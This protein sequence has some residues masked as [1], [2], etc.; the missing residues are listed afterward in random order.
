MYVFVTLFLWMIAYL[1]HFQVVKSDEIV[2]SPYNPRQNILSAYVIRGN[3][4][5]TN[6]N[7]LAK[8][9]VDSDGVEIRT[10]PMGELY[11]HVVGYDIMGK[12]GVELSN[13]FNLLTSNAFFVEKIANELKEQKNQGDSIVTSLDTNLQK[14][15]YN[16]LGSYDGSVVVMEVSTGKILASVSKPSFD[17]SFQSKSW[18]DIAASGE[19]VLVNRATQG[20]YIPGSIFKITTLIEY[21][22]ENP[23]YHNYTYTCTGSITRGDTT[24]SCSNQTVHGKQTLE[25]AFAN[26]CNGAFIEIGLGLDIS[27]YQETAKSLLFNTSLPG[28]LASKKSVFAL[29]DEDDEAKVMMTAMGQGDTGV[30][31][32]HMVMIAAAI[33]NDGVLMTPYIVDKIENNTGSVVKKYSAKEYGEIM[34]IH[35]ATQL[36]KYM[37]SVVQIGTATNLKANSYTVAG[38]TGTA[39]IGSNKNETHSWFMGYASNENPDIAISVIVEESNGGLAATTVAKKVFETYYQ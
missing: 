10:Y 7:I 21:M 16:A 19:S 37:E 32:Y 30:S 33:A 39:E 11:A 8:S 14:A 38:K 26:S 4:L 24:I 5:D 3:I 9:Q 22:R 31:P 18:E 28:N 23:N 1:I 13:N 34:S 15:A 2:N 35:E 27:S 20:M 17:P 6:G 12:S 36:Q 25:E 29:S